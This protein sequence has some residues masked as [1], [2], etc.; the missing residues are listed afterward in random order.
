VYEGET[1]ERIRAAIARTGWGGT[2]IDATRP[3]LASA[4]QSDAVARAL[5]ELEHAC[6]TLS[7][8]QPPDFIAGDL[9]A[10]S[11]ALAE[12]TGGAATEALLDGIFARFC[13]GK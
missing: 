8:G 5:D 10:A 12:I 1:I 3:H 11:A 7:D 2:I 13:I 9:L 6:A 4:R